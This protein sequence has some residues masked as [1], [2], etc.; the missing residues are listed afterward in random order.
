V[1]AFWIAAGVVLD[2]VAA[3]L[4]VLAVRE[5]K[6]VDRMRERSGLDRPLS[7]SRV[8]DATTRLRP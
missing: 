7:A 2:V 6:R 1:T 5:G 3:A 4:Y 8:D